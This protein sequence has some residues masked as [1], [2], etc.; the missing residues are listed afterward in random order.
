M[1]NQKER[2]GTDCI[3]HYY[4][5]IKKGRAEEQERFKRFIEQ[6]NVIHLLKKA[7]CYSTAEEFEVELKKLEEKE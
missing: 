7:N 6:T 3:L 5:G 1:T 4:A 2:E